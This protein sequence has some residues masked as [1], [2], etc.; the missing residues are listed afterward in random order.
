MEFDLIRRLGVTVVEVPG[1][2]NRAAYVEDQ[3]VALVRS[4]QTHRALVGCADWL[5]SEISRPSSEIAS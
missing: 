3:R 5:L 1:L 2:R 4:G